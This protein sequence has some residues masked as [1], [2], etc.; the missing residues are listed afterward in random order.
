MIPCVYI[1]K[2]ESN[3]AQENKVTAASNM[4]FIWDYEVSQDRRDKL[5]ELKQAILGVN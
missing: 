1:K 4:D 5:N 3:L 2:T